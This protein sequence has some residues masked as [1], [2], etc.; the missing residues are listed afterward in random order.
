MDEARLRKLEAIIDK[1][2][3]LDCINNYARGSDRVDRELVRSAYHADAIE[4]HGA[5][6]GRID[7]F[8]EWS[9]QAKADTIRHQHYVSNSSIDLN[10]DEAHAETY[11][12]YVGTH[13]DPAKPLRVVGGRYVDRFERRDG[14]WAIAARANLVEWQTLVESGLPRAAFAAMAATGTISKDK[15]D[16]S[17][18]RPLTLK[19]AAQVEA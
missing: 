3:I 2:E 18:E 19:R 8:I 4:D 5:F 17:Y 7:P 16:A 13:E 10:G 15:S 9:I 6:V 11:Y 1:S 12:L 14:R